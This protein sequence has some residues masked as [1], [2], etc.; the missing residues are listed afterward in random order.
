MSSNVPE[1]LEYVTCVCG[2]DQAYPVWYKRGF[3]IVQCSSCGLIYTNPRI[4]HSA[5]LNSDSDYGMDKEG[6]R[7]YIR[8]YLPHRLKT[9]S[10]VLDWLE[11]YRI[12]GNR[13]LEIGSNAGFFLAEARKSGWK[14]EGIEPSAVQ[15]K[16]ARDTLGVSVH[17]GTLESVSF[18]QG[19]F[20]V[21]VLLDVLEH[22]ANPREALSVI[23]NWVRP[24]GKL[25]IRVPNAEAITDVA[26]T[27]IPLRWYRCFYVHWFYALMPEQHYY[28]FSPHTL[29]VLLNKAGFNVLKVANETFS[30][31]PCSGSLPK[32][33]IK[34]INKRLGAWLKFPTEFLLM[35]VKP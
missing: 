17:T 29:E 8:H 22:L 21:V 20:D 1:V 34:K 27:L 30:E 3:A 11:E 18:D 28:H 33:A 13:L 24:G 23:A 19:A 26:S 2:N 16:Y 9:F 12:S 32:K 14:V 31:M 4:P 5:L 7:F 10:I 35:A 6:I 15:A 25:V